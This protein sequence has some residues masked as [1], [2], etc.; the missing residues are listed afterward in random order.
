M[1]AR[2][3]SVRVRIASCSTIDPGARSVKRKGTVVLDMPA[4]VESVRTSSQISLF[5]FAYRGLL[6]GAWGVAAGS[7]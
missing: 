5:G 6:D 7:R 3:G 1:P 4:P 2:P